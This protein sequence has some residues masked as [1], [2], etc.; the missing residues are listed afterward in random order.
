MPE[1]LSRRAATAFARLA[2]ALALTLAISAGARAEEPGSW[3]FDDDTRPVK[4]LV[5]G[6]S[7]SAY[8]AGSYSQWLPEVCSNIE[9]ENRAKAK[10]GAYELRQRFIAQVLENRRLNLASLGETWLVFN[11]G[12]NSVGSPETTNLEVAKTLRLAKEAGMKTMGVSINPWGAETD[13]RWQ[14]VEGI[15]YFEHTQ[16]TVDFLLGRLTPREAFGAAHVK[17]LKD[18]AAFL[19]GELPEVAVDL[20]TS[21]LRHADAPLRDAGKLARS[22][23][24]S[25]WLKKRLAAAPEAERPALLERL[26][27]QA[28]ALPRWFMKPELIGFDPIH[29]NALGH[30]EIARAICA[31]APPSW[32]CQCDR[33]EQL[34]WDRRSNKPRTL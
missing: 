27:A 31:K 3:R 7:V 4:V 6:G 15:A 29:P 25:A 13:R 26:V 24:G 21:T 34:A 30:R 10:L 2:V 5:L 14:G 16:R 8:P 11:G 32:G 20:W 33:L 23:R 9:V 17:T 28:A 22:A 12:L 18:G 1:R 19:P